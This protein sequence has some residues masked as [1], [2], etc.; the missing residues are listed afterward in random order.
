MPPKKKDTG[1]A[2]LKEPAVQNTLAIT[3]GYK[4]SQTPPS[5]PKLKSGI[6]IKS[7]VDTIQ[8]EEESSSSKA[9]TSQEQ[10]KDWIESISKSPELLLALQSFSK[11]KEPS[12]DIQKPIIKETQFSQK[13][14]VLSGSSSSQ[15]ISQKPSQKS[16]WCHKTYQQNI[17][18]VEDGFYNSDPFI[19][20]SKFFPKGWFF[21]PWDL[22]KPQ[23]FY[24]DILEFTESVKFKHFYLSD[25]HSEPAYS[26][27]TILKVLS[28]K[29]WGES[30]HS[31]Q[32]FPANFH[33]RLNHCLAFSYWDYQQAWFNTFLIQNPKKSHSWLFFFNSKI[34]IES[35]PNWFQHWWNYYGPSPDILTPN[36]KA[37]LNLF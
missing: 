30:L 34:T 18:S 14:V 1:K 12:K 24:Q 13:E 6:P 3:G 35:L 33:N 19:T 15:I 9:V 16:D 23:S 26:T 37:C 25:A 28:P 36:A 4:E 29:Q 22:S 17:L 7:W 21:K 5:I 32:Y 10:V 20:L 2:K 11:T 8:E 27:A 31:L